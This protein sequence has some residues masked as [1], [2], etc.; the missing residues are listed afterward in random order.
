MGDCSWQ[1]KM[2][3][4]I[5]ADEDQIIKSENIHYCVEKP[6]GGN[7]RLRAEYP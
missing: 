5:V 4:K 1:H 3:L 2:L 6:T 7:W